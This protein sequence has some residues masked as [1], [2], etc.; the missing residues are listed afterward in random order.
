M[1]TDERQDDSSLDE[2]TDTGTDVDEEETSDTEET[3]G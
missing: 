1:D 3:T 2:E